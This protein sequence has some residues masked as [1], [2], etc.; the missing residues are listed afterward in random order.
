MIFFYSYA[1]F[2]F[3]KGGCKHKDTSPFDN[4]P[5]TKFFS[6]ADIYCS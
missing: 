3:V 1:G 4:T 2:L 6:T 5:W